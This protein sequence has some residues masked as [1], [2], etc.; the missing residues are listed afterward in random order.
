MQFEPFFIICCRCF[1]LNSNNCCL[2]QITHVGLGIVMLCVLSV[3]T[4]SS[5]KTGFSIAGGVSYAT[6][7]FYFL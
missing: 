6:C 4:E 1:L 3:S 2:N 5:R 7:I